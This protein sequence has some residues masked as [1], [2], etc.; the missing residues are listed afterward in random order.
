MGSVWAQNA[1][2]EIPQYKFIKINISSTCYIN[3]YTHVYI[4][5][6]KN[7]ICFEAFTV[8]KFNKILSGL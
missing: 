3:V 2:F 7:S 5:A 4:Q 1:H 8:T 6:N